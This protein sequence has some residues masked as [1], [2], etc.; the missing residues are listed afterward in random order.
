VVKDDREVMD[1]LKFV[2]DG[3]CADDDLLPKLLKMNKGKFVKDI[4]ILIPRVVTCDMKID[5]VERKVKNTSLDTPIF[6]IPYFVII[7]K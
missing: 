4:L 6:V 5:K 3:E 2:L 1:L 7:I